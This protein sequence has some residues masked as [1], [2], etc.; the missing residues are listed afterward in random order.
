MMMAGTTKKGTKDI[1][2]EIDYEDL[3]VAEV[4]SRVKEKS[5]SLGGM[6]KNPGKEVQ[7]DVSKVPMNSPSAG[8][9]SKSRMKKIL[10]KMM[11]PFAPLIKL[12]V[13][14]V[15]QEVMNALDQLDQTNRRLDRFYQ[16]Q[17]KMMKNLEQNLY[18]QNDRLDDMSGDSD[19][20]QEYIKLLH[21]LAHNLVVEMTKLKIEEENL[22]IKTRSLEKSLEMI[23]WK[24]KALEKKIL[25]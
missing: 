21:N 4:M 18:R 15:H 24:E 10:Q 11:K 1:K 25:Q 3:D 7:A 13:F 19:R 17:M 16:E 23:E 12:L 5:V 20:A 14:P 8:V 9:D 22:K 2:F 6:R